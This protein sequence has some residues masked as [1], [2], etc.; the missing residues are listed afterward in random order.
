MTRVAIVGARGVGRHHAAWWAAEGARV[1]GCA[2]SAPETAALAAAALADRLGHAV[3]GFAEVG[4]M[5]A[6]T[7][8][9]VLDV[10]SPAALHGTHVRLGLEAGCHVLC[11]KPFL[12][13]PARAA[14]SLVAGARA[15]ADL[16]EAR[17]LRLGVCTQYAAGLGAILSAIGIDAAAAAAAPFAA[18]LASP[19]LGRPDDP[20]DLWCDLGPHLV[21]AIAAIHPRA[22]PDWASL[23]VAVAP[24]RVDARFEIGGQPVAIT[25]ERRAGEPAHLRRFILAGRACDIAP[26]TG[27]DGRFALRLDTGRGGAD[28]ED[29]MRLLIRRFLRGDVVNPARAHLRELAW[30]LHV[31]D[32]VAAR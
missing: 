26:R 4:E 28:S 14:G 27:P 32:A 30:L 15:L 3:P 13:D 21:S 23:R 31:R 24:W 8:P 7:R 29:F 11:E 19:A 17:G 16:A 6:A 22:D 18:H 25:V 20:V 9:D 1:A 10:C 12:S 5:L 2:G